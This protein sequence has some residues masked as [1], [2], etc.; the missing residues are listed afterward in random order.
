MTIIIPIIAITAI[1]LLCG[2]ML[3]VASSVM[4]V[5]VDE[6]VE[7]VRA[8]LPGANCGAC[9]Y[10]GCDGYAKAVVEKGAKT[11][12]CVPGADAVAVAVAEILGVEP[13]DVVEQVAVVCCRGD[14]DHTSKKYNYQGID[15]CRGAKMMFGGE[16]ACAYGCLG[17]GDCAAVCPHEAISIKNGI[18]AID[19][20][21]CIGCGLCAKTCP[22]QIIKVVDAVSKTAV[23]CSNQEPGAGARKACSNACIGCRRCERECPEGAITVRNNLATINYL[24]CT[25]C[26]DCAASC[27]TGAVQ[28][29]NRYCSQKSA[30]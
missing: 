28:L 10:T 29:R 19:P 11:N 13:E 20:T 12:L 3:S 17:R 7:Q 6:R 4:E 23:L 1:G 30:V 21:R 22:N 26:G 18:A 9:G 14:C 15:S 8:C 27:P 24:K 25:G 5:K 16:G 2:I